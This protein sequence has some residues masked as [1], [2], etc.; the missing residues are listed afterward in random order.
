MLKGW[1]RNT[2]SAARGAEG[3]KRT[4]LSKTASG[5]HMRHKRVNGFQTGDLVEAH[6]PSGKKAEPTKGA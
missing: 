4:R 5:C 2:S 6:V 1:Q 3:I